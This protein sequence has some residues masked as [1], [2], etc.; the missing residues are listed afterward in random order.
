LPYR[1]AGLKGPWKFTGLEDA[2]PYRFAIN[3]ARL[4]DPA[5]LRGLRT[6]VKTLKDDDDY[7]RRF[8]AAQLDVYSNTPEHGIF[9][10]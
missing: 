4:A 7:V 9:N 6:Y 8:W 2:G 1:F 5:G 3:I 10:H